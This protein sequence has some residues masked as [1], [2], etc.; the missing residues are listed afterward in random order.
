MGTKIAT[1]SQNY[2]SKWY[3]REIHSFIPKKKVYI[4]KA[5][6]NCIIVKN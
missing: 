4:R 2:T 3:P 6:Q 5:L 1:I